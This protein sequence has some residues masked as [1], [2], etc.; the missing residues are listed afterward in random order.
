MKGQ[1]ALG[2]G[3]IPEA[4]RC[5][6]ESA[7]VVNNS[8]RHIRSVF[9]TTSRNVTPH[10]DTARCAIALRAD[11]KNTV[12]KGPIITCADAHRFGGTQ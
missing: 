8:Q 6:Q 9:V 5:S 7:T 4:R 10:I 11:N 3:N 2:F 12:F 1:I